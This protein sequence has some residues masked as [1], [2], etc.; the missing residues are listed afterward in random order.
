M[1]T[2][3]GA[4]SSA[5][6]DVTQGADGLFAWTASSLPLLQQMNEDVSILDYI[7]R[8][9]TA[10]SPV[11]GSPFPFPLFSS[12]PASVRSRDRLHAGGGARIARSGERLRRLLPQRWD[13]TA[14][15]WSRA[16][17]PA[18]RFCCPRYIW[19]WILRGSVSWAAGSQRLRARRTRIE[20]A[21]PTPCPRPCGQ[22][23]VVIRLA[24]SQLVLGVNR[25]A[26]VAT[27][28][29]V[30]AVNCYKARADACGRDGRE[31]GIAA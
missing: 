14:V 29:D 18:R 1:S 16:A 25:T 30:P 9:T 13:V 10:S 31:G 26:L 3:P 2:T 21:P 7:G 28:H 27:R 24:G 12:S 15:A 22:D 11:K 6:V 5:R 19:G 8:T 17:C 23:V 20:Y 4:L